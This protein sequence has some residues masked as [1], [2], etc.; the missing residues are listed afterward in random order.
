LVQVGG[1]KM[2]AESSR[3]HSIFSV[4]VEVLNKTT[5]KTTAGKMSLVDLA[6][7]WSPSLGC[8]AEDSMNTRC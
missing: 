5:G 2:N 3:S 8:D 6:G 4:L 1:T 7:A